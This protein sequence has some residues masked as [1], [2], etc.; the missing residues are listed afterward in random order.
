MIP[1]DLG[2]ELSRAI[3]AAIA[4]GE[5]P[6]DAAGIDAAGTWR[7]PPD[8][9][10]AS[11]ATSL[12]FELAQVSGTAPTDIATDLAER[13][14][15]TRGISAAEPTGGGYLT[16][17]VTPEALAG[18]AVRIARAG[19]DCARST[20]LRGT[21]VPMPPLPDLAA[22]PTW[23]QAWR[24]QAAALTG[25]LAD[26][27][28]ATFDRHLQRPA[29]PGDPGPERRGPVLDAVAYAGA[30]AVRYG[31]ARALT[32]PSGP[33]EASTFVAANL[34]D[35][36][37]AVSFACAD[38][39]STT[40]WAADLG[41]SRGEPDGPLAGLLSERAERELLWRL[42]WLAERVAGAARR[43]RPAE[44]PRYLE[45]TARAW[46]DCR[47]SCPALPFGG[48][49]APHSAAGASARLWLAEATRT[50]LATGL[51]LVGVTPRD[52][53]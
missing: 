12:P 9:D 18:L 3:S 29:R 36:Y 24:E 22:A 52:R 2:A 21:T 30:D 53:L 50:V 35:P 7:P 51:D 8:R 47:E 43:R 23:P 49:A 32:S 33:I 16:I 37:Y 40:R 14:R 17:A 41:L 38:S 46:L 10:D 31:L 34:A 48:R 6:P 42:S 20:G 13:L 19:A 45:E 28:G 39:A 44:L 4:A 26:A 15:E 5:L 1:A 25:R 11:Y 27:A